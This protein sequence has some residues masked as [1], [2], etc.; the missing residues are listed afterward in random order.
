MGKDSKSLVK[1]ALE[2]KWRSHNLTLVLEV[3]ESVSLRRGREVSNKE[4]G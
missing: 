1:S 4:A 3:E 2:W